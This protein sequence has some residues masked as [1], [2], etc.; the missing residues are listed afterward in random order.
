[1]DVPQKTPLHA[2][3]GKPRLVERTPNHAIALYNDLVMVVAYQTGTDNPAHI[4]AASEVIRAENE[5][6]G[7]PMRLL[8]VLPKVNKPPAPAVRKAWEDASRRHSAR[9]SRVAIVVQSE[10]FIAS[11]QRAAI[12]GGLLVFRMKIR[13]A[14]VGNLRAGLE[15]LIGPVEPVEPAL[16]FCEQQLL[17]P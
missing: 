3:G 15:H 6:R 1:M 10:G 9:L 5:R 13:P 17:R 2:A 4:F 8:V 14:V 16:S 7:A 11:V 12:S